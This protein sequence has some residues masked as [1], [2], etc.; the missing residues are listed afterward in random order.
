MSSLSILLL[1]PLI[2]GALAYAFWVYARREPAVRGGRLLA[3]LRGVSLSLLLLLLWNPQ[4]PAG[5]LPGGRPAVVLLDG[6]LSMSARGQDGVD[7]WSRGV[8]RARSLEQ[9]GGRVL[10]FGSGAP[11]FPGIPEGPTGFQSELAPALAR[12]A[13]LGAREITVVS[14]FRLSDPEAAAT[15]ARRLG[16]ELTLEDVGGETRNAGVATF[17]LPP[18]SPRA[19]T[20]TAT[21]TLF[22]GPGM[23]LEGEGAPG[24]DSLRLELREEGLLVNSRP[25]ALPAPGR[26]VTVTVPL[27]PPSASGPVLYSA[28]VVLEGDGFAPDDE[29]L[30]VVDV[31]ADE[32]GLVLLSLLPDFEPRFLLPLLRD[33]TGLR[34]RGYLAAGPD[35]FI[36]MDPQ[37]IGDP[38]A[39]AATVRRAVEQAEFLVLHGVEGSLPQWLMEAAEAAPRLLLFPRDRAGA[40]LAGLTVT[41]ASGGEWITFPELPSSPVAAELAGVPL[42]GLPPLGP[43]LTLTPDSS[44]VAP[45][46]AQL[47]GR[48]LPQPLIVLH[49]AGERRRAVVLAGGFWRWAFRTGPPREV[50]RRLWAGVGGWVL[51]GRALAGGA[52]VRLPIPVLGLGEAPVWTAPGRSGEGVRIEVRSTDGVGTPGEGPPE[53]GTMVLDTLLSVSDEGRLRGPPLPPG[54]YR[55]QATGGE[56]GVEDVGSGPLHVEGWTG[57]MIPLPVDLDL[58]MAAVTPDGTG[59][60]VGVQGGRPLRTHPFPFLLLLGLLCGEWIGRRRQGLR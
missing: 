12:A 32:G 56:G 14:D 34:T 45:L 21:V 8:E 57:D 28:R 19:D 58:A 30:R 49:E 40:A 3:L 6:S 50:Y 27:P 4:I 15:V 31:D 22:G 36:A 37:A 10:P 24:A 60:G 2:A 52:E 9:A 33:I 38:S 59:V 48:G 44:H 1:L 5:D 29:R 23:G 35:R 18:S 17:E 41:G 43:L 53:G 42:T 47:Q 16:I 7:A 54:S 20:L 25:V 11:A 55:W 46:L 13:E 39:D 51:S 26:T